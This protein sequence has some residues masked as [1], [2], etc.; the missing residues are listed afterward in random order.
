MIAAWIYVLGQ[1][2][3]LHGQKEIASLCWEQVSK[4]VY[5]WGPDIGLNYVQVKLADD[6][7]HKLSLKK[8]TNNCKLLD[9][10]KVCKIPNFP[11]CPVKLY[12]KWHEWC[13]PDQVHFSPTSN[14]KCFGKV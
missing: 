4:N 5:T 6:K 2:F 8:P 12:E 7:A 3:G 13:H 1:F 10:I 14:Y 11:L 9:G